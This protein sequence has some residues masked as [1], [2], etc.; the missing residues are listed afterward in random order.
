MASVMSERSAVGRR[1]EVSFGASYEKR[2][3]FDVYDRSS[4]QRSGR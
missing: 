2:E 3:V 4:E 1:G